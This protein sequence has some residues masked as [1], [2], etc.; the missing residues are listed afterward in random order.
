MT[1]TRFRQLADAL[2]HMVWLMHAD[3]SCSWFNQ[4]WMD[5]SGL[6]M[7]DSL[8][9]GWTQLVH[10]EDNA[11]VARSCEPGLAAGE[12]VEAECRLRRA[13]GSYS[14]MLLR[15][16]P[17]PAAD[18]QAAEWL[19]SL[20]DIES[21][22]RSTE[23]LESDLF[24]TRIAGRVAQLGGWTIELP[25]RKLTWSDENCRIHDVPPGY[26]PTLSEGI[27]YFRQEDRATVTRLVE[28]CAQHGTPYEFILPKLT[29]KGRQIWVRS[30][31]EAVRDEA[32]NIIRLQ[33]AFQDITEQ[34]EA[35]LRTL[36][37]EARLSSTLENITD[38]FSLM[39]EDWRFVFVNSQAERM[40]R[41]KRG[42]LL[43]KNLWEE[44]PGIAGTAAER[45]YRNAVAE[46]RTA[47]FE[48]FYRPLKTWFA[49]HV[50]P[51]EAGTAVYFQ[52][53]S[54][55]R[56]DQS[57]LRLL[58]TAVSRL[59][60]IV[61]IAKAK[62]FA[63]PVAKI[64]FVNDAFER[65]TGYR[66]DEAIGKAPGFIW[67]GNNRSPQA[68]QINAAIQ[69]WQPV[70]TEILS[71]TKDGK[72]LWL[73]IDISPIANDA[74]GFTHWVAV[75][76]DVTG[77]R[78]QQEE[79]LRLNAGLEERVNQRTGELAVANS[80]MESFSY[81][82]SHDLRSPLNT[83][84]GF[85]HLLIKSEGDK[86]SDKGKHYLERIGIAVKQMG[87]LIDGLLTLAHLSR[88]EIKS[89]PVDFSA[90]ARVI[91]AAHREREPGRRVQ[92]N[93]QEGL[94]ARG[95]PMLLSA[96]LHHLLANAWKFTSRQSMAQIDVGR[97]AGRDG[98]DVFFVRD[99]GTG[100]D[101]AFAHKLFGIFERLHS[102]G[103]FGG[104]GIGLATVKRVMD[105]HGGRVW[106]ESK[107]GEG[108]CFY[109]TL[110]AVGAGAKTENTQ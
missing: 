3:G 85:S 19:A 94:H 36:A 74:G 14:W 81:S 48:S 17:Q 99:N 86:L 80:E 107:P 44:F 68:D 16:T 4:R 103:D 62:P 46:Q 9:R 69:A 88:Q 47:R 28:T 58:E 5:F 53:I 12:A 22:K 18:G 45:E 66:R 96:V 64:V 20:T 29:V 92:F 27:G 34:K 13:D 109:F 105:R 102:P 10:P 11:R 35:E 97:Q 42:D 55:R 63:S 101:M 73:E 82:V 7:E 60:D 54:Q 40:L 38:G 91:E 15:A 56:A 1:E 108:A 110:G 93:I 37:L 89:E 98:R 6:S 50:Y 75:A 78:Q 100:F 52:D 24:M 70:R 2:P 79:I 67:G 90:M 30:L 76:R 59:N 21:L 39:D 32:G 31:G 41:R 23:M 33:G 61:I 25:E 104:A 72:K 57:R 8:Q 51:T 71:F 65:Q 26:Q 87:D 95:D 49:F 106:A 77:R 43:G 84:H 83:I